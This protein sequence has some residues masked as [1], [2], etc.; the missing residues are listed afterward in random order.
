MTELLL[1][2][3][4]GFQPADDRIYPTPWGVALALRKD[5]VYVPVDT[6]IVPDSP[7]GD[8]SM[9][10][11]YEA[12]PVSASGYTFRVEGDRLIAISDGTMGDWI[13][14]IFGGSSVG[15]APSRGGTIYGNVNAPV[16]LPARNTNTYTPQQPFTF[17]QS[18]SNRNLPVNTQT[19]TY[20]TPAQALSTASEDVRNIQ[21]ALNSLIGAG[22][23]VDG[24]YGPLTTQAIRNFQSR[25]G[26]PATGVVDSATRARL[27]SGQASSSAGAQQNFNLPPPQGTGFSLSSLF[28]GLDGTTLLLIGA[29][30]VVVATSRG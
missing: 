21:R 8:G 12:Q 18:S 2:K 5:G 6:V 20:S 1:G 7:R 25:V 23:S 26:L 17:N 10:D 15:T 29:V 11:Y 19:A 28:G 16:T 3:A 27:F 30:V 13:S 22:L 14:D 24:R 9:G 4:E